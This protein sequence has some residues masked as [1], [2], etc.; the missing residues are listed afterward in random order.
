VAGGKPIAVSS[1]S[2]S[3]V[4]AV[5]PLVAYYDINGRKKEVLFFYF[6]PGSA[7]D[8]SSY[9]VDELLNK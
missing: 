6:A 3:R 2:I 4:S 7:R 1:Q 5:K 8:E 9:V